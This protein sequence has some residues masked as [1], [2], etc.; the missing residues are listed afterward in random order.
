MLAKFA[1]HVSKTLEEIKAQGLYKNERIITGPQRAEISIAD[2]RRV[3]NPC[4]LLQ[5]FASTT[6]GLLEVRASSLRDPRLQAGSLHYL[7]RKRRNPDRRL[8]SVTNP[9][10]RHP[11]PAGRFEDDLS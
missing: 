2:G 7:P 10:Q 9:V 3:I 5:L 8:Q 11:Q 4:A 6:S 1:D